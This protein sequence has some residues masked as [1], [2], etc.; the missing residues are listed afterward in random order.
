MRLSLL[1]SHAYVPI[2]YTRV[3]RFMW[4]GQF[5]EAAHWK[6]KNLVVSEQNDSDCRGEMNGDSVRLT[7]RSDNL[8][9]ATAQCVPASIFASV[10]ANA[11]PHRTRIR[12]P[13]PSPDPVIQQENLI[14]SPDTA[15]W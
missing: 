9:A 1:V 8:R 5:E 13:I 10:V 2:E 3:N 6:M 12:P 11:C 14:P 4:G 7:S 15:L